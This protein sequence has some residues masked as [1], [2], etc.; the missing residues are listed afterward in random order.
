VARPAHPSAMRYLVLATDYDGTIASDGRVEAR[1]LEALERLRATGRKIVLV[2]GR[3]LQDMCNIFPRLQLFDRVIVEN[4]GVLYRPE[5]KEEKPLCEPP[6]ERFVAL[7]KERNVPFSLGRT[8][9]ATWHPHEDAVLQAI[10]DSGAGLQVIFNKDAVMVLPSGVNKGTGLQAALD[11]LGISPHNVVSVGDAEN[12]HSFLAISECSVAVSNALPSLKER[13]DIVTDGARGQGVMEL[14]DKIIDDDL[15]QFDAR[16]LRHA[17]RLGVPM[18][19]ISADNNSAPITVSPGRGSILI[20]GPSASG[21]STAVSGILEQLVEHGYQFCLVDPEGDYDGITGALSFGNAKEPPDAKMVLRA[22]EFPQQSVQIN[23]LGV[24]LKDRPGV[25]S[26]LLPQLQDLR[27]RK[28]RPHWLVIDEA[29][30]LLPSS[31]SAS[32]GTLPQSLETTFLITVHPEKVAEAAL[33]AVDVVVAVGKSPNDVFGSFAEIVGLAPPPQQDPEIQTGEAMV[34]FR[35]SNESPVHIKTARSSKERRR[36]VRQYAEGELSPEQSFYFRG[37]DSKLKLRAQNLH[38]FMD[39]GDGVDDATWNF[40]LRN[41]DY[42]EWF[43][44]IVKDE[45]LAGEVAS[46]EEDTTLSAEESRQKV[47]VAIESRYTAPA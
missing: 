22:L 13:A 27:S 16:L 30:H 47:R 32:T 40:H 15:A 9:V 1:H 6:D 17:I 18:E 29:H 26:T 43:K 41:R 20:A 11:E 31:W 12:D 45:E 42:S 36:H 28:S 24:P 5:T 10:R 3:H 44:T 14:I 39:L 23:L 8:I 46:V 2:T 34:W 37:P 25:F 21:K 38:T 4:G 33:L 7:L 19:S 35:K